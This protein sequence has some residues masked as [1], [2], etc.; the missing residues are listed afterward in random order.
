MADPE[1]TTV[2]CA[3]CGATYDSSNPAEAELHA[4]C[5]DEHIEQA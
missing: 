3:G 2:K 1:T 5:L 4:A